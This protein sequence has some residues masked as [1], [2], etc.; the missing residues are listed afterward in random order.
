MTLV[1]MKLEIN[2]VNESKGELHDSFFLFLFFYVCSLERRVQRGKERKQTIHFFY[3]EKE[4]CIYFFLSSRFISMIMVD[5]L[6]CCSGSRE[7]E[8]LI[9]ILLSLTRSRYTRAH[10]HTTNKMKR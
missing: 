3:R 1:V 4:Q 6:S 5:G 8:V 9:F 2:N 7:S 10:T